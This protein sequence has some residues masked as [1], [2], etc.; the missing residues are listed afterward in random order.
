M[1]DP[2]TQPT[3]TDAPDLF[4]GY[5]D[6]PEYCR[7]RGVSLRTAQRDRQLRQAPPYL[8]VGK[9]VYYRIAAVREWMLN[10]ER[11]EERKAQPARRSVV[12]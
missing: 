5:I 6:E 10:Q 2:N 1:T 12:W 3:D 11:R 7:Q 9:K 8:V 4:E